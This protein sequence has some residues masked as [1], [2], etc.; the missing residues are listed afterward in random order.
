MCADVKARTGQADQRLKPHIAEK[1]SAKINEKKPASQVRAASRVPPRAADTIR[2]DDYIL[3]QV[4]DCVIC[5]D[6]N[7]IVTYWNKGAEQIFGW[8][9]HEMLGHSVFDRLPTEEARVWG[10]ERYQVVM[11][12]EE[13]FGVRH[14]Y[15]RD[16]TRVW[17]EVRTTRMTNAKNRPIG[18]V[19]VARDISERIAAE[20]KIHQSQK[21]MASAEQVAGFGSWE[22]ELGEPDLN[23]N[24]LHWS[25]EVYRIFGL[26]PGSVP[27]SNE[28]FFSHI[29]SDEH[30]AV[31]QAV[32]RAITERGVY[33]IEH[34][35]IR[36]DGE[37][38]FVH[39]RAQVFADELTNR[40]I[41]MVG[42]V[43]DITERR[44]S[45]LELRRSEDQFRSAMQHSSI[46]MA[47][48]SLQGKW[49]KVNPALC[50][51]LGYSANELEAVDFQSITHPD[52]LESDLAQVRRVLAGEIN[53]YQIEKR[54]FHQ[55]G[56]A[57]WALLSVSLVRDASG[58]PLYFIAQI[59]DIAAR[60]QA[61]EEIVKAKEAAEAAT[62]AKSEF[63]AMISHEIRTPLNPVLGAAQLLLDQKCAPEQ[64]ELLQIIHNAGEHLLTLLNDILDLAKMEAGAEQ[65]SLAPARIGELVQGVL[66]IKSEDARSKQLTLRTDV[67]KNLAYAYLLDEPR[68]RQVLLNLV[69]NAIKFTPQGGVTLRVE[70]IEAGP[71]SD[72]L[73]FSVQDTGIGLAPEHAT[74]I[75]EPFFQVDSSTSRRYEGAGLG[76]AICRRLVEIMCGEIGVES[77]PGEGANFWFSVWLERRQTTSGSGTPW[78]MPLASSRLRHVL[79]VE[80]DERTRLLITSMLERAGCE[81]TSVE[82]SSAALSLFRP[83]AYDVVLLDLR[84]PDLEGTETAALFRQRENA[85]SAKATPIIGH[86][87]SD[88]VQ[89]VQIATTVAIDDFLIHPIR[90]VD[91]MKTLN[92]HA[93]LHAVKKAPGHP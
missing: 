43:H 15:R 79:L 27:A 34:R 44:K 55:D 67:D 77:Q 93:P 68:V 30:A 73:R 18:L 9:A 5:T 4:K 13:S 47:L 48:V 59:Q 8:Q 45:E 83:A 16:G 84:L 69:G 12:G 22:L 85:V 21:M 71:Q 17:L 86:G 80:D 92:R 14:D 49:L 26:A 70:R 82:T 90:Q 66:D 37:V 36:P 1:S 56:H 61:M 62:R 6:A 91:L 87:T 78:P 52:D 23:Q 7:G 29:P 53:T 88:E 46:G 10:R 33:S 58:R 28:L 72:L 57:L 81:V 60:K 50:A 31:L 63:L 75:F 19:A 54:Y 74:R 89:H 20:E 39:E 35:V 32:T 41:K 64:R 65:L 25:D 76:L 38:R 3:S 51:I 40:P 11:N 2:R 42:T 24:R